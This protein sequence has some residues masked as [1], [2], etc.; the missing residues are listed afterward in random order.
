MNIRT[1]INV[2]TLLSL[3]LFVV[4]SPAAAQAVKM[5]EPRQEKLLNGLKLLVWN[6]PNSDH[7]TAKLRIHSGSV[8]DPKDKEGTMALLADILFPDGTAQEFFRDD[9]GGSLKVESNFDYIQINATVKPDKFLTMLETIA[10]AV[11]NPQINKDSAAKVIAARLEKVK[12]IESDPSRIGY[13][14]ARKRLFGD[15][16][17]GKTPAGTSESLRNIDFADLI[18]AKERF[19]AADNATLVIYGSVKPDFV[20]KAARRYFGSWEK[21]D[22]K[23]PATFAQPAAPPAENQT[24]EVPTVENVLT[25]HALRFTARGD[26][27]YQAGSILTD[28]LS[29]R[30]KK[31]AADSRISEQDF[32]RRIAVINEPHLLDGSFVI[33]TNLSGAQTASFLEKLHSALTQP[34]SDAEFQ[35]SKAAREAAA[36]KTFAD[37]DEIVEAWLDADTFKLGS[38]KDELNKLQNVKLAD[39]QRVAA[40]V[41]KQPIVSV[42]VKRAEEI[43]QTN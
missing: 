28:I 3:L 24:I 35:K 33:S 40:D 21:A 5:P 10:N 19:L 26:E 12:S 9:L 31:A 14:A 7:V 13:N 8:F 42:T 18:L 22:K 27:D 2:V 11:A 25:F 41:Q 38:V 20:Y 17:Y 36:Q 15:Y 6:A 32:G 30:A 37:Q 39:V 29:D 16:P 23:I 4:S 43:K 34:I 1:F